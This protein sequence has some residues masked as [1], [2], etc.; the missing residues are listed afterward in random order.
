MSRFS[1]LAF[2][3]CL[4]SGLVRGQELITQEVRSAV[5]SPDQIF[6]PGLPGSR[7]GPHPAKAAPKVKPTGKH[8][9]PSEA[10]QAEASLLAVL[11]I[12]VPDSAWKESIP[13]DSCHRLSPNGLEFFLEN[14]FADRL[15][16]RFPKHAVELIAPH[17]PLLETAKVR[18]MEYQDSLQFPWAKWFDGYSQDLIYRPKDRMTP[19]ATRRRMDRLG[20]LLG[21]SHLLLPSRVWLRMEPKAS[22]QHTGHMEW[23]LHLLLWNVA[24]GRP[25]WAMAFSEK[26]RNVDLDAPLDPRLDRALVAAWDRMPA[27][28]AALWK[29]EPY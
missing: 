22:N 6:W 17:S 24:E 27:S 1:F 7:P 16:Q 20:G 5:F 14:Y 11:P 25:E 9:A 13:C 29:A 8:Q 21:A 18:L 28:L 12:R 15:R 19:A 26:A 10:G 3:L 23:G 2:L 4:A